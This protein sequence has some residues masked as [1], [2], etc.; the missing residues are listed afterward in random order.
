MFLSLHQHPFIDE[1]INLLNSRNGIQTL[2]KGNKDIPKKTEFEFNVID[3]VIYDKLEIINPFY[4]HYSLQSP[5]GIYNWEIDFYLP[6][7]IANRLSQA[8]RYEEAQHWYHLIFDPTN[9][10]DKNA[11]VFK[12]FKDEKFDNTDTLLLDNDH[13]DYDAWKETPF[14]PHVIATFRPE[15]YMIYTLMKYLD[16]L[17]DWG[18]ML[19]RRDTIESINEATQYY[20][21]ASEILGPKPRAIPTVKSDK[22]L[23]Y[24]EILSQRSSNDPGLS[25]PIIDVKLE[26]PRFSSTDDFSLTGASTV[27]GIIRNVGYFKL[28]PNKKILSY[29]DIVADRLFKIRNSMNIEGIKRELPLFEPPIDPAMLIRAAQAGLDLTSVVSDLYSPSPM[30]RFGVI[31]QKAIEYTNEVKAFGNALLAALEKRDGEE[32]SI[33]RARHEKNILDLTKQIKEK[34]KKEAEANFEALQINHEALTQK[35]KHIQK[36][37][38]NKSISVP[39]YLKGKDIKFLQIE[40]SD[41]SKLVIIEN[42]G[43][44]I[45]KEEKKELELNREAEWRSNTASTFE[46]TAAI[47]ANIP[48]WNMQPWGAGPTLGGSNLNASFNSIAG[49]Y[50]SE[51]AGFNNRA[52]QVAKTSSW[53]LRQ[54]EWI[55][56]SKSLAS[57]INNLKKQMLSA[58]IKDYIAQREIENHE[59]QI[60]H[61]Q[62]VLDFISGDES[63]VK[64][65]SNSVLYNWMISQLKIMYKQSYKM[66][67]DLAKQA[68]KCYRFEMGISDSNFIQFD[69]FDSDKKGLLAGDRLS[70]SLKQLEKSYLDQ[71]KRE[72]EITKHISLRQINPLELLNLRNS[73]EAKCTFDIPETLFDMDFPG[74]Y[75]R[76]IKSISITMPCIAGPYTG[77]NAT[78]RLLSSRFRKNTERSNGYPYKGTADDRFIENKIPFTSIAISTGQNDSGIFEL[79]FRDERYIP[80]EGAGAISTWQLELPAAVKQFDY[81]TIS[82]VIIHMKYTALEDQGEFKTAAIE[83]INKTIAEL[84]FEAS[85][86]FTVIDLIHDLPMEWH[87]INESA[88]DKKTEYSIS[89]AT[90]NKFLPS[91]ADKYTAALFK[92]IYGEAAMDKSGEL[93]NLKDPVNIE[94][95]NLSDIKSAHL[96]LKYILKN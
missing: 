44:N 16:N 50:K 2:I 49:I 84:N 65:S 14:S 75:K 94:I 66:A 28:P 78:L 51:A 47:L 41:F 13:Q 23:T 72:F 67:Y 69:Y 18:D 1:Y 42:E 53:I 11:W 59:K 15:A 68:E 37:L 83:N 76:R 7:L 91:F 36:M 9:A 31:V 4:S 35:F 73:K 87:K 63:V 38:G 3:K 32:L 88:A 95:G 86:L 19:F 40:Q 48:N 92:L 58:E 10:S 80:F 62:E 20:I 54:D 55:Q 90:L 12:P 21:L 64:F 74:H 79:N 96:I 61:S 52:S 39:P 27:F 34:Q 93:E 85:G 6:L 60:E 8:Q 56:Q 45:T 25:N 29:W 17:I 33:I 30:Y 22:K 82:D 26:F 89:L 46:N 57:E 43:I 5:Y 81:N 77:I 71:N 70:I 24:S